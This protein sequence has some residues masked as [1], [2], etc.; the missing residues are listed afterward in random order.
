MKNF[1]ITSLIV[2][3][4]II[5]TLTFACF[6]VRETESALVTRFG[7]KRAEIAEPGLYVKWPVPIERLYKFDSRQRVFEADL[8]E[9][10]TK[11]AVP[12]IVKSYVVWKIEEPFKFFNSVGTTK[13]AENKLL[14]QLNSTQNNV[15]GKHY[16]SEFVNTNKELIQIPEIETEMLNDLNRNVSDSYGISITQLG[17]KQL[18]I[19]EDVSK[20]VFDRMRAERERKTTAII[21]QGKAEAA[22]IRAEAESIKNSLLA[23]ANG[24]AKAIKGEGDAEAAG[25][26][27]MLEADPE[28]AMFLRDLEALK[29][30]LEKR[31]TVVLSADT[32]PFRLLK[33]VPDIYKTETVEDKTEDLEESVTEEEVAAN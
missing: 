3:V 11:G 5:L 19:S 26:Y 6:Q 30:I 22:R 31:S 14:S 32:E 33:E 12:I 10:T 23:A 18:K 20:D 29:K 4:L 8:H 2:I 17:I 1:A 25:Y 24:R 28:F 27:K 13:E 15:I 21:T 16:F 7:K 9:T